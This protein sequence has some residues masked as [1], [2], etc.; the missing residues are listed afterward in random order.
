MKC[1]ND[2]PYVI[3]VLLRDKLNLKLRQENNDENCESLF[4]GNHNNTHVAGTN[5]HVRWSGDLLTRSVDGL[6]LNI[7]TALS[8]MALD[9]N[10]FRPKDPI[11]SDSQ[12]M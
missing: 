8:L 9:N 10:G 3:T 4:I 7:W 6:G 5:Y 12:W 2:V 1:E 11:D